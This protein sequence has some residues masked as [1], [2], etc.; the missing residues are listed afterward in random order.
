MSETF[1]H[2]TESTLSMTY[3][4]GDAAAL[5]YGKWSFTA[6]VTYGFEL[7]S[8]ETNTQTVTSVQATNDVTTFSSDFKTDVP[9][10]SVASITAYATTTYGVVE[11]HGTAKC[12]SPSG[13]VI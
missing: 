12:L 4:S 8:T 7:V 2:N 5:A 13:Q 9:G 1:S 3:T 11:W 10:Q 6:S